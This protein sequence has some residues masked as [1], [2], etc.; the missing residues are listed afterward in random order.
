MNKCGPMIRT[1]DFKKPGAGADQK[2]DRL[3]NTSTKVQGYQKIKM[4]N[5][6][7]LHKKIL[8]RMTCEKIRTLSPLSLISGSISSNR[9]N[10]PL[11]TE[12]SS[13]QGKKHIP[14]VIGNVTVSHATDSRFDSC[15]LYSCY[16]GFYI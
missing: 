16:S 4:V 1:L 7:K 3:C 5:T 9:T 2:K 10:L 8:I 11:N 13:V 14:C 6:S 12:I 15:R